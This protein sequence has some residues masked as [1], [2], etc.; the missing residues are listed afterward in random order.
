MFPR[1]YGFGRELIVPILG[2]IMKGERE[3]YPNLAQ[4]KDGIEL[5]STPKT[6]KI[7]GMNQSRYSEYLKL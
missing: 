2:F 5:R 6:K 3:E 1:E 7:P 4:R